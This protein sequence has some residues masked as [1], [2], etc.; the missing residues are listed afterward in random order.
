M[1]KKTGTEPRYNCPVCPGLPM[2]KLQITRKHK[3]VFLTLDCCKRCGGVWFDQGEVQLSQQI[4]SSKVR[5]RITK[6]TSYGQS[7]CQSC[8][9]FMDRN[10]TECVACGWHNQ[11]ACPVCAKILQCERHKELTL[12]VCHSC[13]G[14]WFDQEEL[15]ALWNDSLSRIIKSSQPK[16]SSQPSYSDVNLVGETIV[17]TTV[18]GGLD[19]I[20]PGLM[21][22]AD[23]P[24]CITNG[25]GGADVITNT[26]EIA[27]S[28]VESF[29]EVTS[30]GLEAA[31]NLPEV[32]T[33]ML[34]VT[35]EVAGC[36]MEGLAELISRI[37]P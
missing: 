27:G 26:P 11:I 15:S 35:G 17:Q 32:A 29:A 20:T 19:I 24:Q 9:A 10:Q 8:H 22:N 33:V 13:K 28:V 30:G 18:K 36:M 4:T 5:Q 25:A 31:G 37:S 2:Q 12:D 23:L 14:V 3:G 21:G 16:S 6:H 34:E 7:Y 1:S